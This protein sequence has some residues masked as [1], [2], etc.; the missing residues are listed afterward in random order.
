[1]MRDSA[2]HRISPSIPPLIGEERRL[3]HELPDG[4]DP[5]WVGGSRWTDPVAVSCGSTLSRKPVLRG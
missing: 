5:R 3:Q 2:T 1:M 4:V